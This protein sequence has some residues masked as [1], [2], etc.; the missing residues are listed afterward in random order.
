MLETDPSRLSRVV[1]A[2]LRML[3]ECCG[4]H[5][6]TPAPLAERI[7]DI[8]AATDIA[9][10]LRRLTRGEFDLSSRIPSDEWLDEIL[11]SWID[12]GWFVDPAGDGHQ[13]ALS[14]S[15]VF[16]IGLAADDDALTALGAQIFRQNHLPSHTVTGRML[17]RSVHALM[18]AED[19]RPPKMRYAA[20]H[21]NQL[22]TARLPG[23]FFALHTG[24]D[25]GNAGDLCLFAD[26]KPLLVDGG[27][28]CPVRNLPA[29]AGAAQL[30]APEIPCAADFETREDR[31]TLSI[32][33][34]HAYPPECRLQSFQR[35]ALILRGEQMLRV[36][37]M[38]SFDV[39]GSVVFSFVTP[40]NPVVGAAEIL[41]GPVRMT[42]EG[43]FTISVRPL[44]GGLNCLEMAAAS[45]VAQAL[46]AFNFEHT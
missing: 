16:R 18:E 2:A 38:V 40:E 35:S 6:R 44:E 4:R 17:D 42:W 26:G 31:E 29:L 20:T 9:S 11:F 30:S 46:F 19:G 34:T 14:G 8:A 32:E 13:P 33:L 1:K 43:E 3:D 36:V 41:L 23:I 28:R 10:L 21:R 27:S 39:P 37:D 22:M 7:T 25:R 12:K 15:D 45:P 24:G 5:G